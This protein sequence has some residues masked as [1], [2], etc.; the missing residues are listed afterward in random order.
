MAECLNEWLSDCATGALNDLWQSEWLISFMEGK[1]AEL[2]TE[3]LSDWLTG[4]Q[5]KWRHALMMKGDDDGGGG[6]PADDW[7]TEWQ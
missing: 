5:S 7:V 3:C 6:A 2:V 1:V 4:W